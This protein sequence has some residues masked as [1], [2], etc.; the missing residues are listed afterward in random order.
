M[1][2]QRPVVLLG[3]GLTVEAPNKT[4]DSLVEHELCFQLSRPTSKLFSQIKHQNN[5]ERFVIRFS[6]IVLY[7][8]VYQKC[9]PI[10]KA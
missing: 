5:I 1:P 2:S 8:E 10:Y 4:N 6:N 7:I 3:Y 9:E